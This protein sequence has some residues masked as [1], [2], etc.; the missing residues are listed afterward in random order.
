MLENLRSILSPLIGREK[1]RQYLSLVDIGALIMR[2]VFQH[3]HSPG[4]YILLGVIFSFMIARVRKDF[5][6]SYFLENLEVHVFNLETYGVLEQLVRISE[7]NCV[8]LI[9]FAQ[10]APVKR[11]SLIDRTQ[12]MDDSFS[13]V[14]SFVYDSLSNSVICSLDSVLFE[15]QTRFC[16]NHHS[17]FI[18]D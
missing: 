7:T 14:Q 9:F 16:Q 4:P 11:P 3:N 15:K 10:V 5:F 6:Q 8:V 1:L 17:E 13:Y 18:N 12:R 2:K